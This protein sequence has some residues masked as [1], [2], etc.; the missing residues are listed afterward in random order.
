MATPIDDINP[1]DVVAVCDYKGLR[2][3][4]MDGDFSGTPQIVLAVSLP[5]LA[6]N[7]GSETRALD[8]RTWAVQKLSTQFVQV[9]TQR[10]VE[11]QQ[12]D[13]Y[14]CPRCGDQYA[15][16]LTAPSKRGKTSWRW[17]CRTCHFDGGPASAAP[18][19][20]NKLT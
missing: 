8:T 2:R 20:G 7:D 12:S 10:Q 13:P 3:A 16:K 11:V 9:M 17:W 14:A 5:F 4:G 18:N 6:L 19:K 15:E 1:G